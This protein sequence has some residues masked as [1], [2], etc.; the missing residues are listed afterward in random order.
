M[1]KQQITT[2]VN[3]LVID[4]RVKEALNALSE[5]VKGRDRYLE[6]DLLL[7]TASFNRNTRD[8]NN[9][10]IVRG[11]Y[12]VAIAKVTYA[13]TQIV[14]RLP[15]EGNDVPVESKGGSTSTSDAANSNDEVKKILFLSAG[16]KGQ[17]KLRLDEELRKVKDELAAA[18][19]RD[20]F[21]LESE[22]AVQ[23]RVI[24]KAMQVHRPQIV[25]F[26]GHGEE[27]GII[28][29]NDEGY[30]EVFPTA[31]LDRLFRLFKKNVECV[32]LNACYSA[33]HAAAISKHGI[34]VVGMNKEI[35]DQSSIDFAV[36]FYQSLGE[37][38]DYRFAFEMALIANAIN[39]SDADTP[40]LWHD[41]RQL[42]F[43][44]S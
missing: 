14:E 20:K 44:L 42:D 10:L 23:V 43:S 35:L 33:A 30:D 4:L 6:N 39:I 36:G 11:D 18:T 28:V 16:A 21:D 9:S 37:G 3:Q 1:T 12:D 24:T 19:Y 26:S 22:G 27:A 25:H 7:Q 31:G 34:Y 17:R 8:F 15:A 2:A 32:V 41:G 29:E 13:I 38:N 40:V 5:Y